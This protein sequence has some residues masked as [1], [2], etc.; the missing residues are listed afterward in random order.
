[1]EMISEGKA[2]I[3]QI[4]DSIVVGI[5]IET[6]KFRWW[7]KRD[8]DGQ[9]LKLDALIEYKTY[10]TKERTRCSEVTVIK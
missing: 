4:L 1:V 5:N 9:E 3:I 6:K 10:W 2:R 8:F 7:P